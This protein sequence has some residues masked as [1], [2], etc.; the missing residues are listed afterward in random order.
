MATD[1]ASTTST[2]SAHKETPAWYGVVGVTLALSSGLFIGTSYILKKRGLLDAQA[3]AK[4]LGLLDE[5]GN[6]PASEY[7]KNP[8]WW[9]GLILMAIGEGANFAAYGFVPAILV[10]PLGALSVVVSAIL[11]SIFL[12]ERLSFSGKVGCGQCLIGSII[13]VLHGPSNSQAET[14]HAFLEF[15]IA[16]GFIAYSF[17]S[18]FIVLYLI[19]YVSP[20]YGDKNPIVY[21][22]ICSIVGSFLVIAIEGFGASLTYSIRFWKEDNQF[23][24]W[25]MYPLFGLV[26]FLILCEIHFLNKALNRFS[27]AVVT[28]VYYVFFTTMTMLSSSVLFRGFPVASLQSGMTVLFGFMVIVG[29]VA[30]LF[31]YSVKVGKL[32]ALR[33]AK[34]EARKQPKDIDDEEGGLGFGSD[35]ETTTFQNP[36]DMFPI[37]DFTDR[38]GWIAGAADHPASS[39]WMAETYRGIGD[40]KVGGITTSTAIPA[41][42]ATPNPTTP[43]LWKTFMRT[44][45][46]SEIPPNRKQP[47][48][49]DNDDGLS[50][51]SSA[52][53]VESLSSTIPSQ[54]VTDSMP[55]LQGDSKAPPPLPHQQQQSKRDLMQSSSQ[56]GSET[57]WRSPPGL[58]TIDTVQQEM[59]TPPRRQARLPPIPK[60]SELDI[61]VGG[62]EEGERGRLGRGEVTSERRNRSMKDDG[63]RGGRKAPGGD[64]VEKDSLKNQVR[65]RPGGREEEVQSE[66]FSKSQYRDSERSGQ[67]GDGANKWSREESFQ[68][69]NRDDPKPNIKNRNLPTSAFQQH[70]QITTQVV[71]TSLDQSQPW[72]PSLKTPNPRPKSA[73]FKQQD[74]EDTEEQSPP[75][76]S[77]PNSRPRGASRRDDRHRRDEE[78]EDGEDD[79]RPSVAMNRTSARRPE[80]GGRR[81][82]NTD[83]R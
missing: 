2:S 38:G 79:W 57:Q 21:I 62:D 31:Q 73:R 25:Q 48:Q 75:S 29:G 35:V 4:K 45:K 41:F 76:S 6:T 19:Y 68:R 37:D 67:G 28:P 11:S 10:T 58:G 18:L 46:G 64:D 80:A 55:S 69:K 83:E 65:P 9:S 56:R 74:E 1:A 42:Q 52:S 50:F 8:L 66:S 81:R 60:D 82:R 63:R 30:L 70:H 26:I 39:S 14:L 5:K 20:R 7:L 40:V 22:S 54:N 15:V 17:V 61:P 12:N 32:A 34:K 23:R 71:P 78:E 3:R 49:I 44:R 47:G 33:K 24:H 59:E 36:D 51:E 72:S 53:T 27:T 43:R 77:R 16:P 13:I